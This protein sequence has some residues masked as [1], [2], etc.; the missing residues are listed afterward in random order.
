MKLAISREL[1]AYWDA[2]R[3]GRSAPER[4]DI[5]PGAIRGVLADTFVLDFDA[6]SGFP[7]R[8]AG[9]RANALFGTELR[10]LSFLELWRE[11]D[12]QTIK[13][14]LQRLANDAE[15]TVLSAE[16]RPPGLDSL[17]IETILLPL[18]H[19]GS[20]HSRILGAIAVEAAPH[21]IGLVGAG[22]ARLISAS[23]P[24]GAKSPAASG[25]PP[26]EC[27]SSVPKTRAWR[28]RLL[29][30]WRDSPRT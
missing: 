2:L 21:W 7:F 26:A 16:A 9:S 6:E 25:T 13:A 17:K 15:P 12:R 3:A 18:R 28:G 30:G 27:G 23:A 22:P 29:F 24:N 5:E 8:I 10:G 11:A 20:T 19:H 14:V 4:N 1:Y